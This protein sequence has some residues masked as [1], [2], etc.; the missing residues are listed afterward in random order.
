MTPAEEKKVLDGLYG[1]IFNAITYSPSSDKPAPFDPSRTLI[2][3]SKMEAINPADFA[4]QLAPNNLNG[5]YNTAFNF[6]A[7]T[8]A[9]PTLTPTYAPSTR[10]VAGT[11][12]QIVTNANTTAKVDPKQKATY[13]ANYNYLNQTSSIPNPA[14]DPPTVSIVPSTI[15]QTYDD[16]EVA[17]I[18]AIGGYRT[19]M[20]A[21]DL[22]KPADQRAWNAVEPGLGLNIT[23]TWNAWTRGGKA[24]VERAQNALVATINDI[25][26][27]VIADAQKAVADNGWVKSGTNK[28]L[29]TYPLPSDWA[30]GS[31]SRGAS[32]FTFK[33][34]VVNTSSAAVATSYGG[35]ASFGGG[36]WSVGGSYNHSNSSQQS[37]FDGTYVEIHAKMTLV[38]IVR[39]WLNSLLFSVKGWSLKGQKPNSVSNGKLDGNS[40]SLLPLIPTAF[41]VMSNVTIKSDFS[42]RDQSIIKS[43]TSGSASVG[44]GPFSVSASYS[45]SSSQEKSSATYAAGVLSI[46][47]MQIV[48]WVSE[49]MPASPSM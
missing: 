15:A 7:L 20:L 35:G 40:G 3:L 48:A 43:A 22:T 16:N 33:S 28:F 39:P 24:N 5:D 46:P 8:D 6:F 38:R 11:F 49:I 47:G 13:E 37:H 36:L 29:L 12:R 41:V 21:Y 2:Q 19:A 25:I 44:W 45:H 14:P 1:T 9:A 17:Y 18:T 42:A 10:S 31:G 32:D 4:N 34:S 26:S 30:K 27:S 23:K